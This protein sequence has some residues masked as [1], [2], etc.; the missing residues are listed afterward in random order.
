MPLFCRKIRQ[1]TLALCLVIAV[2]LLAARG[3]A[4]QPNARE[5]SALYV[6]ASTLQGTLLQTRAAYQQWLEEQQDPRVTVTVGAWYAMDLWRLTPAD[7][8]VNPQQPIDLQAKGP[9]GKLLWLQRAAWKDET[10]VAVAP[11]DTFLRSAQVFLSRTV[12]TTRPS[13]LTIGFGGGDHIDFWLNGKQVISADTTL[14]Y[15][16]YGTSM[17]REGTRSDQ[18]L[19]TI[20]LPQGESQL[21]A[22]VS[23]EQIARHMPM[24]F[25]F[26]T[27]PNP[28]PALWRCIEKDYPRREYP[29]LDAVSHA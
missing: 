20:E 22:C 12:Q 8:Q 14:P 2:T 1:K 10:V 7:I 19:Y 11:R 26:S 28:I 13:R 16:R 23:Q 5:E 25:Y 27:K 24:Q 21:L 18:C 4:S 17:R 3:F 29:L 15:D 9:D 6:R